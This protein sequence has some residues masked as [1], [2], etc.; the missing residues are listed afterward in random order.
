MRLTVGALS[1]GALGEYYFQNKTFDLAKS[2][3][4][5]FRAQIGVLRYKGKNVRVKARRWQA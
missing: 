3:D 5:D 4:S 1:D 2:F